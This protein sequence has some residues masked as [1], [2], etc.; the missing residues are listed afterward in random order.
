MRLRALLGSQPTGELAAGAATELAQDRLGRVRAADAEGAVEPA[1]ID[2]TVLLTVGRNCQERQ[3]QTGD[4]RRDDDDE[5]ESRRN[6]HRQRWYHGTE[7][8]YKPTFELLAHR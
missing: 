2:A 7:R 3:S 5:N 1:A 8:A 6:L 4:D